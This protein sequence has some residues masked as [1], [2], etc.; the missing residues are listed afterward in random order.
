M[1]VMNVAAE[2]LALMPTYY[3][4]LHVPADHHG[5]GT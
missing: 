2:S 1:V 5:L 3:P 4:R